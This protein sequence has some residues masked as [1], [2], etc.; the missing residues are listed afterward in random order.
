M[1]KLVVLKLDGDTVFRES[2]TEQTVL[3]RFL[4]NEWHLSRILANH[5]QPTCTGTLIL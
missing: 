1:R 5:W 3:T 4:Q 2:A